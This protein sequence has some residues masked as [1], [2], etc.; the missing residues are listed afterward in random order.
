MM[1]PG[2]A[3]VP[4]VVPTRSRTGGRTAAGTGAPAGPPAAPAEAEPSAGRNRLLL[5]GGALG[6]VLLTF[7]AGM[8]LLPLF[9]GGGKPAPAA[10]EARAPAVTPNPGRPAPRRPVQGVSDTEIVLGMSGP[11]SGPSRELGRGVDVGLRTYFNHVNDEGGINGRKVKLVALDDGYEPDRAL[12]NMKKLSDEHQVFA[13]VGSVGTPTAKVAVPYAL[14]KKLPFFGP[15]T[16]ATLLRNDPPDRYV[17]NYRASYPEETAAMVYYLVR[18]CKVP[19]EGIVVFAQQD[20]Y[21]DAGFEGVARAVRDH[22]GDAGAVLRVG[23][24]RNTDNVDAAVAELL[25]HRERIRAI[26][27]VPTYRPAALFIKKVK[28]AGMNPI[29]LNVSFVGS[30]ALAEELKQ[31]GGQYAE[32]VI[33]TQVVPLPESHATGVLE[34]RERLGKYYPNERPSFISLEGYVVAEV[35]CDALK[36]SGDDLNVDSLIKALEATRNLDLGIGTVIN[37]GMSEHQGSHKVWGSVLDRTCRYS[38]LELN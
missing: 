17:F 7:I 16:G 3:S 35:F 10:P 9:E 20:S 30:E 19:P 4:A 29:F 34:Y 1:L 24:A 31:L 26:V 22:N 32:G 27:M 15:F 21:G 11:F 2:D 38:I 5:L 33:V 13:V 18:R 6:L 14:E 37:Y 8:L 36:R 23:Y 25:R 12:E 28:D